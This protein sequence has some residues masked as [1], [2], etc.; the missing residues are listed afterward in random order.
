M[1]RSCDTA[2]QGRELKGVRGGVPQRLL[3]KNITMTFGC[4]LGEGTV[5]V[6]SRTPLPPPRFPRPQFSDAHVCREEGVGYLLVSHASGRQFFCPERSQCVQTQFSGSVSKC[7]E[8]EPLVGSKASAA[9]KNRAQQDQDGEEEYDGQGE[10][11]RVVMFEGKLLRY[12]PSRPMALKTCRIA[13][14]KL[15]AQWQQCEL[16]ELSGEVCTIR[17]VALP[18]HGLIPSSFFVA[19]CRCGNRP[20][21]AVR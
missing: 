4:T 11:Q 21:R 10:E 17:M 16:G 1:R 6:S 12:H 9:A 13:I 19:I 7:Y 20:C 2:G 3:Q 18:A 15:E 5:S 8:V 14:L